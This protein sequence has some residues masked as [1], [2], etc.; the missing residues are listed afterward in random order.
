MAGDRVPP[1]TPVLAGVDR[2]GDLPVAPTTDC[3]VDT[4]D[5]HAELAEGALVRP[6]L[7]L[8]RHEVVQLRDGMG[9]RAAAR[10][11]SV[12]RVGRAHHCRGRELADRDVI[13]M[14]VGAVVAEGDY[15]VW[16]DAAEVGHELGGDLARRGLIEVTVE[17]VQEVDPVDAQGAGG[18][19]ELHFSAVA[20]YVEDGVLARPEPAAL[21]AGRGHQR[22][23]DTFGGIAGQRAAHAHRFIVRVSKDGHQ[24]QH[25][26]ALLSVSRPMSHGLSR[27]ASWYLL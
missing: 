13:G 23:F 6:R 17:V 14:A 20:E 2:C 4:V 15:H 10:E 21:A 1:G 5:G 11:G 9:V 8:T 22:D 24:S 25:L 19:M 26:G 16:S 7:L 27:Q 3:T 18:L 12:A